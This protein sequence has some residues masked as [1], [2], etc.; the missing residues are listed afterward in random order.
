MLFR[1]NNKSLWGRQINHITV[2]PPQKAGMFPAS[3]KYIVANELHFG[4]IKTQLLNWGIPD[5]NIC[6]YV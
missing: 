4:D 3:V 1:S 2:E 5:E 6:N